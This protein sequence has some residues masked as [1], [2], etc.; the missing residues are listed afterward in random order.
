MTPWV[1]MSLHKQLLV[2]PHSNEKLRIPSQWDYNWTRGASE[3]FHLSELDIKTAGMPD[4]PHSRALN[5]E[6][7]CWTEQAQPPAHRAEGAATYLLN[8]IELCSF[9]MSDSRQA[10]CWKLNVNVF[11]PPPRSLSPLTFLSSVVSLSKLPSTPPRAQGA[12]ASLGSS[13]TGRCVEQQRSGPE[14]PVPWSWG[15]HALC[16]LGS[17]ISM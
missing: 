2:L 15:A 16:Y 14:G 13:H 5:E 3:T 1:N 6:K 12:S 11:F 7:H 10:L 17:K 9:D 8:F 4:F